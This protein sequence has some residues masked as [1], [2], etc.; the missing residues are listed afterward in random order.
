[1][2]KLI[3]DDFLNRYLT[4]I[5]FMTNYRVAGRSRM[6][7][8]AVFQKFDNFFFLKRNFT[9]QLKQKKIA[10]D[11]ILVVKTNSRSSINI[12]EG[13]SEA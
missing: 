7:T 1:M 11:H 6:P 2:H 8:E 9:N 13:E 4:M 5:I 10:D 3:Y 12:C